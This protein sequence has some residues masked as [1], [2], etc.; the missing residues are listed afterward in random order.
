MNEAGDLQITVD[1]DTTTS[2]PPVVQQR[3]CFGLLFCVLDAFIDAA[4]SGFRHKAKS[5]AQ[6]YGRCN[7]KTQIL[8]SEI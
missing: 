6:E 8:V 1:V 4:F 7:V 5:T 2:A 3:H